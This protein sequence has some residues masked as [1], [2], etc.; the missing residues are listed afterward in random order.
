VV[1]FWM[2]VVPW[3][4]LFALWLAS[5]ILALFI[6]AACAVVRFLIL[7]IEHGL[8]TLVGAALAVLFSVRPV[9]PKGTKPPSDPTATAPA[10]EGLL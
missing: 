3:L 1:L 2:Q 6:V 9:P 5:A 8:T 4:I 7:W 10:T